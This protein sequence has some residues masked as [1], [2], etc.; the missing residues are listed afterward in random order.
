MAVFSFDPEQVFC[1]EL[2]IGQI[3]NQLKCKNTSPK[4]HYQNNNNNNLGF[5][6]S[7]LVE[8]G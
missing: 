1:I 8:V 5:F 3:I 6:F 7:K 4:K 2:S